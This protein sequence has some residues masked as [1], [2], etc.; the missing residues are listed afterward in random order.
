MSASSGWAASH[1]DSSSHP[2]VR[3]PP[4]A[5]STAPRRISSFSTAL[6]S[7]T[8]PPGTTGTW[9][10][11]IFV[12]NRADSGLD[13]TQYRSR[14]GSRYGFT[15]TTFVPL[16]LASYRYFM[17]TGWFVAG[18]DPMSTTRSVSSTSTNEQVVAAAPIV[19]FSATDDG[20]W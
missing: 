19:S 10:S 5:W 4:R 18:L 7:A 14:P 8:S 20:A 17:K 2:V 1:V 11:Q 6:N 12:P 9:R 13:G 15:T 3:S 16:R